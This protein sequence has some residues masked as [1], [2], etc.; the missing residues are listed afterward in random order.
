[1][2]TKSY[3]FAAAL[4]TLLLAGC[5]QDEVVDIPSTRAIGFGTYVGNTTRATTASDEQTPKTAMWPE[6][7]TD[8]NLDFLA[9]QN[10]GTG[11]GFYVFGIYD[12]DVTKSEVSVF[13]GVS[14]HAHVKPQPKEGGYTWGYQP[15]NYWLVGKKYKF[16]AYGPASALNNGT[17]SFSYTN[18]K[19]SIE[20][21]E[22]KDGT[23]TKEAVTS[24]NRVDLIVAEGN[25]TGYTLENES[26]SMSPV[27][28]KFFHALSK[29]RFTFKNGWRNEVTLTVSDVKV[30]QLYSKGNFITSGKLANASVSSALSDSWSGQNTLK[31]YSWKSPYESNTYEEEGVYENFYIPQTLGQSVTLTFTV[32]VTNSLGGGPDLG[33]AE[34]SE[35]TV[36]KTIVIPTDQISAWEPGKYYNYILTIDGEFFGLKPIQFDNITVTDWDSLTEDTLDEGD[37]QKP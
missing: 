27:S 23:T 15:I 18:N 1:M 17:A 14:E 4:A 33:G 20:G 30:G 3:F 37:I 9:N 25:A 13:D 34:G 21:F 2:K 35:N 11:N 22:A 7:A 36:T 26:S 12:D 19:L 5:T 28:F 8:T 6:T 31:V 16:A 24:D 32:K 10:G 29:V